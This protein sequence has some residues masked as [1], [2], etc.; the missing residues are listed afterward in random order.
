MLL[1][2]L[3]FHVAVPGERG[4]DEYRTFTT[5][6][7]ASPVQVTIAGNVAMYAFGVLWGVAD[8]TLE[9]LNCLKQLVL[10]PIASF[11]E[12][13]HAVYHYDK[14]YV[15]VKNLIDTVLG[16]Y[17]DYAI[18]QKARLHAMVGAE[19]LLIFVPVSLPFSKIVGLSRAKPLVEKAM[20]KIKRALPARS[21]FDP[22]VAA[23]WFAS[24]GQG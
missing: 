5:E 2:L 7:H 9:S 24:E 16:E 4:S 15:S 18:E 14:T 8:Y 3:S 10:H 12:L 17:P 22:V 21:P 1:P 6:L 11:Q 20:S 19:L 23:E 13:G